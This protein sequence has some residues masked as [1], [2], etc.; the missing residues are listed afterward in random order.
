MDW[1]NSFKS[2]K[3]TEYLKWIKLKESLIVQIDGSTG[4]SFILKKEMKPEN[5]INE[6]ES[7]GI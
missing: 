1:I 7:L 2:Y 3:E 5:I 6:D 4:D